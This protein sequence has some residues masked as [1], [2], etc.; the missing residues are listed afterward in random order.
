M[1][2]QILAGVCTVLVQRLFLKSLIDSCV[3]LSHVQTL[4]IGL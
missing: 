3:G 4:M 2:A 1:L